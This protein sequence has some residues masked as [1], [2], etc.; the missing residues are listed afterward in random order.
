[1]IRPNPRAHIYSVGYAD[2]E[3]IMGKVLAGKAPLIEGSEVPIRAE[4]HKYSVFS[5]HA[6][7]EEILQW[8]KTVRGGQRVTSQDPEG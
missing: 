5:G 1:M 3:S 7:S 6:D 2:E 8:I 4:V